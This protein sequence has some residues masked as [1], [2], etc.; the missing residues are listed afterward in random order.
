MPS[1]TEITVPQLARQVG[2]PTAPAIVDVRID[3]DFALD[4]SLIPGAR[5]H[6]H[7][8]VTDW[9]PTY[10]GRKVV[11]VCHRGKKLSQGVAALLRH[12]GVAAE[13]L[14]GGFE[15]WAAA[16]QP[17]VAAGKLP[18]RDAEGRT[19]WVTRARPKIDRTAC[20]WLITR[21]LDPR[22]A[23]LFVAP[24]EV[25]AV[26]DKFAATPFDVQGAFWGHRGDKC[27]FDT[28]LEE[29]ALDTPP[30][31]HMADIVRAADTDAPNPAP[32][33]AGLTAVILGQSRMHRD[34]LTQLAAALPVY[35]A[36]YRWCRDATEE[37]HGGAAHP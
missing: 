11:V 32:Q 1:P 3:D 9:A 28:I 12:A 25:A 37:T 7:D 10:A 17:V 33:A 18:P 13:T 16:G 20:P 30:L 23:F 34:D 14:E 27:T 24:A 26:A 36:L 31:R 35:D 5:R 4:T 15:A 21:F 8:T 2:L 6:T 29:C 19:V 22:A